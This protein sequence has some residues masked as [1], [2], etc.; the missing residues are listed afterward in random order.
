MEKFLENLLKSCSNFHDAFGDA[1][2]GDLNE[3]EAIGDT[4][5]EEVCDSLDMLNGERITNVETFAERQLLSLDKGIVL[6]MADGSEYQI[7][8]V[9]SR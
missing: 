5:K 9:K 4:L 7:T 2:E 3:M 1:D 6:T 8:I